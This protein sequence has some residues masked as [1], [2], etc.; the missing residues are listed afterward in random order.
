MTVKRKRWRSDA[1]LAFVR[2][3]DC[4]HCFLPGPS[5]AHHYHPTNKGTGLKPS[6]C[7]VAPLCRTCHQHWHDRGTLPGLTPEVSR[8]D[9]IR[10]Q[11]RLMAEWIEREPDEQ[12]EDPF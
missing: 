12:A 2:A 1:Y 8:Q 3:R 6:D 5:E 10:E 11:W 7:H 9:F 4:M